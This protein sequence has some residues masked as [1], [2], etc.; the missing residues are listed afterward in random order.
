MRSAQFLKN[1]KKAFIKAK[2]ST[3]YG[4]VSGATKLYVDRNLNFL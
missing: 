2:T 1:F 4:K 3:K